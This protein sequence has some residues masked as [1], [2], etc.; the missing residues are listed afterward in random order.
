MR[1]TLRSIEKIR[2]KILHR[3]NLKRLQQK[4]RR[5]RKIE[6]SPALPLQTRIVMLLLSRLFPIT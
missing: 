5:Q 3:G 2:K 4:T 6:R 1:L